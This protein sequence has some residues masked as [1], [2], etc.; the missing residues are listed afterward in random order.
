MSTRDWEPGN[1][2]TSM[3]LA[4]LLAARQ[5][6]RFQQLWAA[7]SGRISKASFVKGLNNLI[8]GGLII[9]EAQS[10]KHVQF[11]LN[12]QN[13]QVKTALSKLE[14]LDR[15]LE[16]QYNW[17]RK[18][19]DT[20]TGLLSLVGKRKAQKKRVISTLVSAQASFFAM[21]AVMYAFAEADLAMD[22]GPAQNWFT[23]I[24][25][26]HLEIQRGGFTEILKKD[27]Q[28]AREAMDN[29]LKKQAETYEILRKATWLM[30]D[31]K[32]IIEASP[33]RKAS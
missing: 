5:P 16:D 7:C 19:M 20:S 30:P 23:E 22:P 24:L 2:I 11:Q 10:R 21:T 25:L 12:T 4:Q 28:L 29:W 27:R 13:L 31:L 3:I 33:P 1:R 18:V 9:R 32:P 17:Y 15:Q 26:R 14:A 8:K 6:T